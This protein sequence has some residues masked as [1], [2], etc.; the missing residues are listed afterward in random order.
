MRYQI[1]G[2]FYF[3]TLV[4]SH[5]YPLRAFAAIFERYVT[6]I[7]APARLIAV[8]IS[9]VT[10][11]SFIQPCFAAPFTNAYSPDTLYA[12]T[13]ML[14]LLFVFAIKSRYARAGF[15]ITISTPS[16]MSVSTSLIASVG[17]VYGNWY[18]LLS[19]NCGAQCAMSLNGEY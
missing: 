1:K 16:A 12:A 7:S 8:K 4:V 6:I 3:K 10:S 13:G 17:F 18:V 14:N 11:V 15:I 9:K 19:P 2:P 5:F